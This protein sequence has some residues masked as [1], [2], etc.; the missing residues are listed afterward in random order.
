MAMK[1]G[2]EI[3]MQP[4]IETLKEKKLVGQ[5]IKMSFS[6][7]KTFEL[8]RSFMPHRK[9]IQ[10]NLGSDLYSIE[11]YEPG[12]FGNFNPAREFDKWAAIEVPDFSI[13]PN[14]METITI[15]GG[16]YAV[17]LYIGPASAAAKLYQ[18][19]FGD[20]LPNS[21]FL[22]DNRPHFALMGA[23]YKSEGPSSE[24]E[25]WIPIKLKAN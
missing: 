2:K 4:G 20:W 23:K 17:F 6:N 16:L 5:F 24:E 14:N 19:I 1:P 12:F 10:N 13:V 11:V 7:N 18:N 22:L 21:D 15:P 9:E 8:W 25:I 3:D